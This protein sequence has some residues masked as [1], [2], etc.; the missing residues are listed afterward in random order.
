VSDWP[1]NLRTWAD[2]IEKDYYT[3]AH[4]LRGAADALAAAE[5]RCKKAEDRLHDLEAHGGVSEAVQENAALRENNR[6]LEARNRE[7]AAE[8]VALRAMAI[9]GGETQE[10]F[11]NR[12]LVQLSKRGGS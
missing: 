8:V 4:F 6:A 12:L 9:G 5:A 10:A 2:T 11:E 1:N 7:L 3:I